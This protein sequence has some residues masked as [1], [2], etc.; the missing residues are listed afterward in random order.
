M[1]KAIKNDET[2]C[3]P[4]TRYIENGSYL[5]IKSLTLGYNVPQSLL[6]KIRFSRVLVYVTAENLLTLTRYSGFDPEVSAFGSTSQDNTSKNTAPGVDYG[7]YP[8]SRDF[9]FGISVTF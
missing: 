8:Q 5:R 7:T 1:P 6:D 3:Y 4:S 9:L 2:N